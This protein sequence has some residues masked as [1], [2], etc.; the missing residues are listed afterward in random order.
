VI[1]TTCPVC[2]V[3]THVYD[4]VMDGYQKVA[5]HDDPDGI[6]CQGSKRRWDGKGEDVPDM[7]VLDSRTNTIK[8]ISRS[9]TRGVKGFHVAYIQI[10][11][12]EQATDEQKRR[13]LE[14][15]LASF[16]ANKIYDILKGG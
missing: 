9:T 12:G 13:L 4:S 5:M 10:A 15:A 2:G 1:Y 14:Q 11:P 3:R 8:A 7:L 16:G 6:Q